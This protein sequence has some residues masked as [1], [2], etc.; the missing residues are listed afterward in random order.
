MKRPL[1]TSLLPRLVVAGVALLAAAA[2][3]GA[4]ANPPD[5][6]PA[7]GWRDHHDRDD[8]RDERRD[9]R[10]DPGDRDERREHEE[11]EHHGPPPR[12]RGY[13]QRGWNDDYGVASGR[14]NRA[15]V[16]AVV[17]GV[18]GGVVGA[19]VTGE[20]DRPVAV[21]LGA[22]LGSL[23][24]HEIG[25]DMDD[26]DRGCM[27]H[28]LELARDGRP[29]EWR[30]EGSGVAYVVTPLRPWAEGGP[31]CREVRVRTT[32]RGRAHAAIRYACRSGDG[33]W[34]FRDR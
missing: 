34:R 26:S 27:G 32:Y 28:T 8:D 18:V 2:P 25:R 9:D 23:V 10:R 17:G 15:A 13:D 14:C 4:W 19:Q 20:H 31:A 3:L 24:G 6:A 11:H 33:E 7:H 5:W 22:L 21:V 1:S 16:G 12:Y 30:N 29:V